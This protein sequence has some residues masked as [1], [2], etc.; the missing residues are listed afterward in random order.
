[1]PAL[2]A[3]PTHLCSLEDNRAGIPGR[4]ILRP[5]SKSETCRKPG[6]ATMDCVFGLPTS[7]E[8]DRSFTQAATIRLP[9]LLTSNNRCAYMS[10]SAWSVTIIRLD[11]F[12][13]NEA[14]EHTSTPT[15]HRYGLHDLRRAYVTEKVLSTNSPE[16][17]VVSI[18]P[19]EMDRK[20]MPRSLRSS[21]MLTR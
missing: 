18:K 15:Y 4:V 13:R 9:R 20:P 7:R 19:S 21:I 2:M 11:T 17:D 3:A 10:M 12:R 8:H 5:T 14:L 1:M 16:A 6:R